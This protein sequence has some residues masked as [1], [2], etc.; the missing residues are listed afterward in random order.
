MALLM[1][2]ITGVLFIFL[3]NAGSAKY[4]KWKKIDEYR[5]IN[6]VTEI[7]VATVAKNLLPIFK[8]HISSGDHVYMVGDGYYAKS[9]SKS[10]W[11]KCLHDW[12]SQNVT[13]HY[14]LINPVPG[15]KDALI[16]M[17]DRCCKTRDQVFITI[18]KTEEQTEDARK[19]A[20]LFS[21][22]HPTIL[23]KEDARKGMWLEYNHPKNSV[24]SYRNLFVPPTSEPGKNLDKVN[25]YS[26]Y[27][28]ILIGSNREQSLTEL[29]N[30]RF[31]KKA[32]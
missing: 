26:D 28:D 1:G 16:S 7:A 4:K 9:N 11:R 32:A 30:N 17:C 27:I 24:V 15:A 13:F 14:I 20:N 22:L 23:R 3:C 29:C 10:H 25:M 21:T 18:L 2:T 8:P 19:I 12:F 6:G 5:H 31:S